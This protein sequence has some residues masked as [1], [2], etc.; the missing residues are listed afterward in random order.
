[1]PTISG[2]FDQKTKQ[3]IL[4]C[5]I[6]E[7]SFENDQ[8]Q[9]ISSHRNYNALL[10]TG[11]NTTAISSKVITDLNLEHHAISELETAAGM[12]VVNVYTIDLLVHFGNQAVYIKKLRVTE[13]KLPTAFDLLLGMD[14]ILR[15]HLSISFDHHFTFSI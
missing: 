8:Q 10:D 13:A 5:G 7:S 1:M 6:A 9:A 3:I 15:G 11:A 4:R 12:V 14:V 2:A